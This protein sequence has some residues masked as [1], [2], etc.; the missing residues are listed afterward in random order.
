MC[1]SH[2]S[3]QWKMMRAGLKNIVALQHGSSFKV[4]TIN[5]SV[6]FGL[7]FL[8]QSDLLTMAQSVA[9][10]ASEREKG[11]KRG[12]EED[13]QNAGEAETTGEKRLRED[14][15]VEQNQQ[16]DAHEEEE[17]EEDGENK[18]RSLEGGVELN[19]DTSKKLRADNDEKEVTAVAVVE[20]EEKPSQGEDEVEEVVIML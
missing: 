16:A 9:K 11:G 4:T 14:Q 6:L 1:G 5:E 18:K 8:R 15:V 3:Q 19:E 17:E 7:L 12:R 13:E 20:G 10:A 2:G